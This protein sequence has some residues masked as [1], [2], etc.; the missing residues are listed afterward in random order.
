MF[1]TA[2]TAD[3][4]SDNRY[5]FTGKELG[6]ETGLYDFSARFLHPR[7][8]RFTTLDPLAEKSYERSPYIYCSSNPINR[9]DSNGRIDWKITGKGILVTVSG[10]GAIAGGATMTAASGRLAAGLGGFAIANGIVSIGVGASMIAIG[11]STDPSEKNEEI[12]DKLPTDTINAVT[13]SADIILEN[14]NNEIEN[15][16]SKIGFIYDLATLQIGQPKNIQDALEHSGSMSNIILRI[17]DEHDANHE[18][19]S[20]ENKNTEHH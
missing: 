4:S 18:N 6:E 19:R 20:N 9:I 7:S 13:K 5:R 17:W 14:E 8:G 15:A 1:S 12:M 2:G 16:V 10:A 3:N 11:L